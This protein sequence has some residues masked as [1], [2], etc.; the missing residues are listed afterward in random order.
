MDCGHGE[1]PVWAFYGLS[2]GRFIIFCKASQQ[3]SLSHMQAAEVLM[4]KLYRQQGTVW[5]CYVNCCVFF[6]LA[7]AGFDAAFLPPYALLRVCQELP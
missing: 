6:A 2:A 1:A 3:T 4:H 7:A 5:R